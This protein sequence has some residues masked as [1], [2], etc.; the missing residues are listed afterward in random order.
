VV[1]V[2]GTVPCD[3]LFVG[4]APGET[5]NVLGKPFC[6]PA[7]KLLDAIL[8]RAVPDGVTFA[9]TNL[10]AC[11]PRAPGGG[12]KASQ[13]EDASIKA[14]G[15]RLRE[16]IRLAKPRLLVA[17]GA[18]ARDWLD[19]K[20]RDCVLKVRETGRP[21]GTK[22][23]MLDVAE[24]AILIPTVDIVHP[25]AVLRANTAGQGLMVQRCVVTV[26]NAVEEHVAC[27]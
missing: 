15:E 25:A 9:L 17:V 13:P 10:V 5:E 24:P 11:I 8:A 12:A 19:V 16:L 18:L 3:V 26:A 20:V 2:R 6:G 23:Q 7:G 1:L 22:R 21:A 4:E 27:R 14:C